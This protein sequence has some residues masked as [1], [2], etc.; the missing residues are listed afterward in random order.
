MIDG[1]RRRVFPLTQD[2]VFIAPAGDSGV[3]PRDRPDGAIA[4]VR[5]RDVIGHMEIG[6]SSAAVELFKHRPEDP[7]TGE[8]HLFSFASPGTTGHSVE[9]NA[10]PWLTIEDVA[11]GQ[12]LEADIKFDD[13]AYGRFVV[14]EAQQ[15]FLLQSSRGVRDHSLNELVFHQGKRRFQVIR[16]DFD[17][18]VHAP[19]D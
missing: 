12:P 1:K 2:E 14:P 16:R 10:G 9:F 13:Y 15:Y 4:I 3:E 5:R 6:E 18:E 17:V 7:E 11:D 19:D 8:V